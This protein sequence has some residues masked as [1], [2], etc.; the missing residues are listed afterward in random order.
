[1]AARSSALRFS[2][3]D[4]M[5]SLL[6]AMMR[7]EQPMAST[8]GRNLRVIVWVWLATNSRMRPDIPRPLGRYSSANTRGQRRID[9]VQSENTSTALDGPLSDQRRA[10]AAAR[11][12][13]PIPRRP[14]ITRLASVVVRSGSMASHVLMSCAVMALPASAVMYR[15]TASLYLASNTRGRAWASL[16]V[17]ERASYVLWV[18][19]RMIRCSF[20]TWPYCRIKWRFVFGLPS[21]VNSSMVEDK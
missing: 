10:H 7:R 13:L 2:P 1:M 15:L 18:A 21:W 12:D 20:T 16:N 8:D 5:L 9:P 3:K 17:S 11:S 19:P 6:P 4:R 14:T